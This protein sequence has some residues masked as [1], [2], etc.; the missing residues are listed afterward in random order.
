MK[1]GLTRIIRSRPIQSL[2]D[3][4]NDATRRRRRRRRAPRRPSRHDRAPRTHRR[5]L[6]AAR[7]PPRGRPTALPP[8][9][10]ADGQ[11]RAEGAAE[12]GQGPEAHQ[13][14]GGGGPRR[15][16][17]R[18][19]RHSRA[20]PPAGDH[21]SERFPSQRVRATRPAAGRG[22]SR[23]C[24]WS[25]RCGGVSN[26]NGPAVLLRLQAGLHARSSFLRSLVPAV[27]GAELR[28][29]DGARRSAGP[30]GAR[31]RR[32]GQDRLSGRP[33]AAARRRAGDRH[34]AVP[35][36]LGGALRPRTGFR[37]LGGTGS[38][39]SGSISATRGAWRRCA[40]SCSP[41]AAGWTSSST[42]RARRSGVRRS[43]TRT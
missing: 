20:A 4:W 13:E 18:R 37:G 3:D 7:P 42:T 6:G 32:A 25:G 5:G 2:A 38:R 10:R 19:N 15:A 8:G 39:S 24:R 26:G 11:P 21:D 35:A 34:D 16:D 33:Q 27:R 9:R 28:E 36:Q 17:A 29:A 14:S 23:S 31:H 22:G 40:G 1:H 41:R 43:S 12:N 30:R